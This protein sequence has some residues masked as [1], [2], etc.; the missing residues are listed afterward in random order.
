[1]DGTFL[2]WR[3]AKVHVL[4]HG[5]HYGSSVFEGERAYQGHIFESK[6][7]TRRLFNS[8]SIMGMKPSFTME[9]IET[10][11]AEAMA[12]NGFENCYVRPL[13]WRGSEMMGVSAQQNTIRAAVA[14]WEWGNYFADKMSGIRMTHAKWRRP[15]P[16]TAPCEAK[17]AGLYMICT[18]SKHVAEAEGYADALMLDWRGHVAEA[19]G[20]NIFF[21]QDGAIHTPTPDCFLNGI[22]RQ[23]VIGLARA[24]NYE[25][26]ERTIL[27]EELGQFS[28]CFITG[29]AAEVT[30]VKEIAGIHYQPGRVCEEFVTAYDRL[31]NSHVS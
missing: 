8:A 20:A 4:T 5:L 9:D 14:V 2:P 10:A 17:A 13:M 24:K 19:T 16:K 21:V 25:V 31:V 29:T 27:P 11:K 1:M 15:D 6:R 26:V 7:H 22:T 12:R 18:D 3:E 30:P 28:E 23:T